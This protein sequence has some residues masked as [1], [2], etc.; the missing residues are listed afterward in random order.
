MDGK[1]TTL[2]QVHDKK[3]AASRRP[4]LFSDLS[5]RI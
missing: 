5:Y 2:A 4:L 1:A 3:E